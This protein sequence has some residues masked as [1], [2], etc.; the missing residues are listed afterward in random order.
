MPKS[1]PLAKVATKLSAINTRAAKL[2]SDL[3]ELEK[4]VSAE[5]K[6]VAAAPAVTKPVASGAKKPTLAKKTY[7]K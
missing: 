2:Q 1:N 5:A 6:K 7:S 4:F 3:E